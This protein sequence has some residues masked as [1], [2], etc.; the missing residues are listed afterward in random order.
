MR[1][2]INFRKTDTTTFDI[3]ITATTDS[4]I[5]KDGS[6]FTV[7]ASAEQIPKT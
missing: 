1:G 6:S 5:T 4:A 7:T 3:A 2:G